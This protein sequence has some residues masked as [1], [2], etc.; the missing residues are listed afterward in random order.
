SLSGT[1]PSVVAVGDREGLEGVRDRWT[2]R[3]GEIRLLATRNDGA[4]IL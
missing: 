3:P 1:G 4:R 2:D